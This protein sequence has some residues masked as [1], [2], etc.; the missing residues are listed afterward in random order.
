MKLIGSVVKRRMLSTVFL[1]A[2]RKCSARLV[3]LARLITT[4]ARLMC[5]GEGWLT[6]LGGRRGAEI[7]LARL[8]SQGAEA[9]CEL[10]RE[11]GD[12]GEEDGGG[13]LLRL[14]CS[15]GYCRVS[16]IWSGN[17][18]WHTVVCCHLL[19]VGSAEN[20]CPRVETCP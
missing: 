9:L 7:I 18:S 5:A 11:V 1:T 20:D 13:A 2:L 6:E 14:P 16:P 19:Y 4:M 15:C 17:Y 8:G 3:V 10:D 12:E